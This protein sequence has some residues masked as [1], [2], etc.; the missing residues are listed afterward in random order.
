M[1]AGVWQIE[2][3]G[4]CTGC[5]L[6]LWYSHRIERGKTGRFGVLMRLDNHREI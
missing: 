4:I 6:N 3:S 1:K 2:V 5:D